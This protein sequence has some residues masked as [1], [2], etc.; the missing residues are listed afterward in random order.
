MRVRSLNSKF[1]IL[2]CVL[3]ILS[4]AACRGAVPASAHAGDEGALKS[5]TLTPAKSAKPVVGA[6]IE[7]SAAGLPP[8]RTVDLLWETVHRKHESPGTRAGRRR[9]AAFHS[10]QRSAGLRRHAYRHGRRRGEAA[11]A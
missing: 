6:E 5:L 10:L 8:N 4:L 1:L 3:A 9:R 11:G 7:A 2:N